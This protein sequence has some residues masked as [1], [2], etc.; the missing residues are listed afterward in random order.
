MGKLLEFSIN[1]AGNQQAI[2]QPGQIISG[3]V[4]INLNDSMKMRG[5]YKINHVL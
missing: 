4:V 2:F 1:F 3:T 5:D